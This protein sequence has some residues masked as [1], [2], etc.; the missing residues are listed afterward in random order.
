MSDLKSATE[1]YYRAIW[2]LDSI[3]LDGKINQ[4]SLRLRWQHLALLSSVPDIDQGLLSS[5]VRNLV[6]VSEAAISKF[7]KCD[8]RSKAQRDYLL[9]VVYR[10]LKANRLKQPKVA[11]PGTMEKFFRLFRKSA[12]ATELTREEIAYLNELCSILH[13]YSPSTENFHADLGIGYYLWQG[14]RTELKE[15][16]TL[17]YLD[18]NESKKVSD[19]AESIRSIIAALEHNEPERLRHYQKSQLHLSDMEYGKLLSEA[20]IKEMQ[21][22]LTEAGRQDFSKFLA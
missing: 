12:L 16:I 19:V 14:I 11:P 18:G 22:I 3:G 4:H 9:G 10:C 21:T 20:I 17:A 5:E 15:G 2:A 7:E 13:Y 6:S 8:S 1:K